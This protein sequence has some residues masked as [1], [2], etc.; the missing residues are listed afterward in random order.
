MRQEFFAEEKY[1]KFFELLVRQ[2]N[3]KD[4]P[5]FTYANQF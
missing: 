4:L 5:V 1:G 2:K 3:L